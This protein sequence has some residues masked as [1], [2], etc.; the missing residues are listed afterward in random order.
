MIILSCDPAIKTYGFVLLNITENKIDVMECK[1][2]DLIPNKK[3]KNITFEAIV[4]SLINELD[5]LKI[6]NVDHILIENIMSYKNPS[7][8]SI[9]VMTYMYFKSKGYNTK[10]VSPSRKLSKEQNK[11]SYKE[12]KNE[13]IKKCF[14]LINEE[15]KNK[16]LNNCKK[17]DDISDCIIQAYEWFNKNK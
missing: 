6:D 7:I 13:G 1:L 10:L 5:E 9:S 14:N 17:I 8:K 2:I 11:L 4:D 15:D 16:I 3:V 12:R